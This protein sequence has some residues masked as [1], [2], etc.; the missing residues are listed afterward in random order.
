MPK[1]PLGFV[2]QLNVYD[3]LGMHGDVSEVG[4]PVGVLS[5]TSPERLAPALATLRLPQHSRALR[6]P[7]LS[8]H[9][10]HHSSRF[11]WPFCFKSSTFYRIRMALVLFSVAGSFG[12]LGCRVLDK[13]RV[14]VVVLCLR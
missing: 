6:A 1:V 2:A 14:A 10:P 11:V 8:A 7:I 12:F 3:T 9:H 13:T 4:V 5:E